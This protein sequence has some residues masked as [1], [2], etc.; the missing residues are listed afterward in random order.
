MTSS[1]YIMG[2]FFPI[3]KKRSAKA[4]HLHDGNIVEMYLKKYN[5]SACNKENIEIY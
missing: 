1:F 2:K 3:C 5:F 4:A